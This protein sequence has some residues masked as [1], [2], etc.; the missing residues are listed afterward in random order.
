MIIIICG[1][2]SSGK[3]TLCGELKEKLGDNWLL[4]ATDG[5][6]GM[7]VVNFLSCIQIIGMLYFQIMLCLKKHNDES[8]E[9]IPGELCSK[10]YVIIPSVLKILA[11]QGFNIISD[12]FITTQDE[13]E[14]YKSGLAQYARIFFIFMLQKK[15]SLKGKKKRGWIKGFC[16]HWLRRFDFQN[17]CDLVINENISVHRVCDEILNELS[18]KV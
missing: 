4:F 13:F 8:Y 16:S 12:S 7:L 9:I 6:L 2:S 1:T 3:S 10:L 15:Q 17:K 14:S 5:Y 18:I 11:A